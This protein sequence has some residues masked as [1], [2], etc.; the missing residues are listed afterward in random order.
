MKKTLLISAISVAIAGMSTFQASANNEKSDL[1]KEVKEIVKQ[2][3]DFNKK[4]P[5]LGQSNLTLVPAVATLGAAKFLIPFM[6]TFGKGLI[7]CPT[8]AAVFA[9]AFKGV[10]LYFI[11]QHYA[12]KAEQKTWVDKV[13]N[14]ASLNTVQSE[15][16]KAQETRRNNLLVAAGVLGFIVA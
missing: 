14:V 10:G 1:E 12:K 9:V 3:K 2:V 4:H 13:V 6:P 7:A 16:E 15:E 8:R 5:E 11:N